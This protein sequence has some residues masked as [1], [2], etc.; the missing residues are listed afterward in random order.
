MQI[1]SFKGQNLKCCNQKPTDCY[2][3]I[4]NLIRQGKQNIKSM[5]DKHKR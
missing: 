3:T 5:Q 2:K 1:I 4:T